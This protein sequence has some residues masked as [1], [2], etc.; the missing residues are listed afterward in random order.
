MEVTVQANVSSQRNI[1]WT[2]LKLRITP[3]HAVLPNWD[4]FLDPFV[5]Q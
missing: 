3:F 5:F 4:I 1:R 2:L